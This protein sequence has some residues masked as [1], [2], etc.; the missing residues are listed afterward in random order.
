MSHLKN[1][2][3]GA[4]CMFAAAALVY[5][6]WALQSPAVKQYRADAAAVQTAL[7][8]PLPLPTDNEPW[9]GMSDAE[10]LRGDAEAW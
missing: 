10:R 4:A 6:V 5:A 7:V 1:P 2:L 3:L 8:K 9:A